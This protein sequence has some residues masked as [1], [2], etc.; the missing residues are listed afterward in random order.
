MPKPGSNGGPPGSCGGSCGPALSVAAGMPYWEVSE[1]NVNLWVKD[2]PLSYQPAKGPQVE[3]T[4]YYKQRDLGMVEANSKYL[5]TGRTWSTSWEG[6]AYDG[7]AHLPGGNLEYFGYPAGTDTSRSWHL[8]ALQLALRNGSGFATGFVVTMPDGTQYRYEEGQTGDTYFRLS[9]IVDPQG[10]A[11]TFNFTGTAPNR[12]LST[13]TDA[14]G[15]VTTLTYVP[16]GVSQ[17]HLQSV[18]APGGRVVQFGYSTISYY[19]FLSSIQD[20]EGITNTFGY[21][22][23]WMLKSMTTPYGTTTFNYTSGPSKGSVLDIDT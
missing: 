7:Y 23:S 19:T 8:N 2:T 21:D 3:L 4:L 18:S 14:N 12:V 9:K 5:K 6:V 15:G 17:G 16:S 22:E 1:P 10:D 20:V 11:L 13:I